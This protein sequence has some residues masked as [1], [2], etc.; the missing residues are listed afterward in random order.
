M[1]SYTEQENKIIII[2]NGMVSHRF[3]ETYRQT[4]ADSTPI[5]IYG[6][7][8]YFAYDRVHLSDHFYGKSFRDLQISSQEWY[9]KN[10]IHVHSNEKV[11]HVDTRSSTITTE[12]GQKDEYKTLIFATGSNPYVPPIQGIEDV[13][14]VFYYRNFND[15]I[16][17]RHATTK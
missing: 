3:C 5:T 13:K 12:S 6:E 7:E 8:P 2:G 9:L 11:V 15:L 1:P 10:N 14:E 17:I 4:K 16:K